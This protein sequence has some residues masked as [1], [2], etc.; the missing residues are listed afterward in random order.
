MLM[1]DEIEPI[2]IQRN[3][4]QNELRNENIIFAFGPGQPYPIFAL[5]HV[6]VASIL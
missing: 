1:I 2:Q 5:L 3:S 4:S 6:Q